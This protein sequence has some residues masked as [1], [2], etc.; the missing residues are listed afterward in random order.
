MEWIII[1]LLVIIIVQLGSIQGSIS[2]NTKVI[3]EL[4]T[5]P[6][7]HRV[8]IESDTKNLR[9]DMGTIIHSLDRIYRET[10]IL[11]DNF[12]TDEALRFRDLPD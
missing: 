7:K 1:C 9:E 3:A 10:A 2:L 5:N 11:R 12:I 8:D 6:I 4:A